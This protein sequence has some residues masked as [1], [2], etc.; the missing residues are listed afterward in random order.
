MDL[1]KYSKEELILTALKSEVD[2][3]EI[4]LSLAD[5]VKN[6]YL[7]DRLKFLAEEEE[8]H[9]AFIG[10][11][12]EKEFPNKEIV[13]PKTT[14]V[15]MPQ[16]KVYSETVPIS[17]VLESAMEAE[18]AANEFYFGLAEIFSGD[19]DVKKMLYYFATMELGHDKILE[20]E[21]KNA[22]DFEQYEDMWPMMHA[23]P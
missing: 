8:K 12:F 20:I 4:Y 9:R 19:S 18:M 23:G 21:R 6:Y 5:K 22:L 17:E 16:I 2:A 10:S 11:L 1:E 15:P 13:L 7:K 14:F 3:K